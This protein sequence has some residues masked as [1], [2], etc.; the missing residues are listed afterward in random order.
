MVAEGAG[1]S[2]SITLCAMSDGTSTC[3]TMQAIHIVANHTIFTVWS[4]MARSTESALR[5]FSPSR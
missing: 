4:S 3:G 5:S 2:I 1:G